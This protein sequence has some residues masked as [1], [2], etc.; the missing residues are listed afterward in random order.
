[1]LNFMDGVLSYDMFFQLSGR[2][3]VDG[4]FGLIVGR[5]TPN[6]GDYVYFDVVSW[7][8]CGTLPQDS[9]PRSVVALLACCCGSTR[10]GCQ[11]PT[12]ILNFNF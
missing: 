5:I 8:Q 6:A 2:R 11:D 4:G 12:G 7:A 1:M 3:D 10:M 9:C